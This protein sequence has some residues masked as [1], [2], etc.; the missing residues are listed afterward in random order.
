MLIDP[1]CKL[2]LYL[3]NGREAAFIDLGKIFPWALGCIR[4]SHC[5][6]G[7]HHVEYLRL[8]YKRKFEN[9][10]FPVPEQNSVLARLHPKVGES[11]VIAQVSGFQYPGKTNSLHL[12]SVIPLSYKLVL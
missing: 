8:P 10:A 9:R 5:H 3:H 7:L 1:E 11:K 4:G 12:S 6:Q 2:L